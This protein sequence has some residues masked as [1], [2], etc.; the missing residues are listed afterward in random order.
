MTPEQ[1]DLGQI[2]ARYETAREAPNWQDANLLIEALT[3]S[4]YDVPALVAEV[5]RLRAIVDAVDKLHEPTGTHLVAEID[6]FSG[7]Q[8]EIEPDSF[9]EIT[10]REVVCMSCAGYPEAPCPTRQ[11]LDAQE[12]TTA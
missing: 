5:R 2:E 1:L 9:E 6:G 4:M 12:R 3:S 7:Q 11:A 10:S 8:R